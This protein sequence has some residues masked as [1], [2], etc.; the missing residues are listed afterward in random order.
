[1]RLIQMAI[2]AIVPTLVSFY[3][4]AENCID[5]LYI[6]SD[7]RVEGQVDTHF[8]Q[9]LFSLGRSTSERLFGD[10]PMSRYGAMVSECVRDGSTAFQYGGF[11]DPNGTIVGHSDLGDIH[12]RY[13]SVGVFAL[14]GYK[15]WRV[16]G[17][18]GAYAAYTE[19]DVHSWIP[20]SSTHLEEHHDTY[21][22]FSSGL[23]FKI[24]IDIYEN[25]GASCV[26][27]N[28]FGDVDKI[29]S[30]R[31]LGCGLSVRF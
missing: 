14:G 18:A 21:H 26:A 17:Y 6:T 25:V 15:V 3:A 8:D 1:M 12:A 28:D 22:D 24:E 16:T 13:D 5:L 31:I 29:G 7:H 2:L 19:V 23:M 20:I 4:Q 27:L 30:D 9:R 11:V 10:E